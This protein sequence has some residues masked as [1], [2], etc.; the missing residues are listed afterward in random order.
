MARY[1]PYLS[2]DASL[3]VC[4]FNFEHSLPAVE[5]RQ[6]ENSSDGLMAWWGALSSMFYDT[7]LG[8]WMGWLFVWLGHPPG[9]KC[10]ASSKHATR[11]VQQQ[12]PPKQGRHHLTH[13]AIYRAV[14]WLI[15]SRLQVTCWL[16]NTVCCFHTVLFL[17]SYMCAFVA[18]TGW[19]KHLARNS[20]RV[21]C[22]RR[23]WEI[24]R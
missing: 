13:I 9:R 10:E 5:K 22:P 11:S 14:S 16:G 7:R 15:A 8:G 1:R 24:G 23:F 17:P 19:F 18:D 4:F 20:S 6:I 12:P 3:S 2:M 21:Q